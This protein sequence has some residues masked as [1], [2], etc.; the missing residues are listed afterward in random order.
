VEEGVARGTYVVVLLEGSLKLPNH[1]IVSTLK[2]L[3]M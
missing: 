2:Q 3:N 1:Q